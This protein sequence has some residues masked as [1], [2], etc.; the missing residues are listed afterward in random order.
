MSDVDVSAT[1][2]DHF[3]RVVADW[4]YLGSPLRPA[5]DD[6][7]VV[8]RTIDGLDANARAIVLGL[9]PETIGCN[10]PAGVK[11]YAVDHSEHMIRTLWPPAK[12]PADA[13]VVLANWAAM[14]IESGS[15]DLVAGDGCYMLL[16]H[17]EGY[18]RFTSEVRRVLTRSGR[19]VIRVFMR[20][21]R[22]ESL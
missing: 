19:F 15:V 6:T 10:W 3:A 21:D 16:N 7:A 8:Q 13:E 20:P 9:T 5:A 4:S 17:P 18:R 1:L 14:P 12:G 11:L 22:A 2:R